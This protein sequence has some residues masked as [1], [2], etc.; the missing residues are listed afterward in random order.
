MHPPL[1]A[2][3]PE[4]FCSC[5]ISIRKNLSIS[6]PTFSVTPTRRQFGDHQAEDRT[7]AEEDH[8]PAAEALAEAPGN[9]L[10]AGSFEGVA[11]RSH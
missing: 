9:N 10:P 3:D 6:L 11:G 1:A 5:L 4:P 7:L 2:P 8:T